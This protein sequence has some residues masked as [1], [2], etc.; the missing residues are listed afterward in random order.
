MTPD[1]FAAQTAA[2]WTKGLADWGQ[3]GARIG[4][5][6]G[7]RRLRHL[8]ARLRRRAA[9]L[10]ARL[11]RTATGPARRRDDARLGLDDGL[12]HPR[13]ARHRRRSDQEPRAHPA[14]DHP[15]AVLAG[16]ALPRPAGPDRADPVA[17]RAD[18]RRAGRR[19]VLQ[20][21]RPLRPGDA[22]QQPARRAR[23]RSVDAGRAA[24]C[25]APARD[26]GGQAARVDLLDRPPVGLRAD[27]LRDAAVERDGGVD[28]RAVRNVVVAGHLLPG[29]DL[30][31]LPARRRAAVEAPAP[32]AAEAGACGRARRR[33]RHPEPGRPRLQGPVERR[34]LA[35][36]APAGRPRQ[37]AAA[38]RPRGRRR[39]RVVRPRQDGA[40]DRRARQARLPR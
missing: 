3:D 37:A 5:A 11:A 36:R 19:D 21:R 38:G 6:E 18:H 2:R 26:A 25:A 22:D 34:H 4:A 15:P 20:G 13:P 40:D 8:H 32:D 29:R 16:R 17:A 9:G 39:H 1:E 35:D 7:R 33:A 28:A 12:G 14:L 31:L 27:V 10:G 24:R 30:R 23:V